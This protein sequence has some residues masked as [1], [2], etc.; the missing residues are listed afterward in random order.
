MRL[1][2][3]QRRG[4][5]SPSAFNTPLEMLGDL[6][7]MAQMLTQINFQYSIGDAARMRTRRRCG[8]RPV[9]SILHWRCIK[10]KA[11]FTKQ[12]GRRPLSILHWRCPCDLLF[13]DITVITT[14]QYSIGDALLPAPKGRVCEHLLSILHWRCEW[15]KKV[16][17]FQ[18]LYAFNTPL[19]MLAQVEVVVFMP[20]RHP[21]NTPLEMQR[22]GSGLPARDAAVAFNTPLEMRQNDSCG[23]R[24]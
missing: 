2:R 4:G 11:G 1:R 5:G 14:F 19:E 16:E 9:L 7:D 15:Q 18:K 8:L 10:K 3:G 13:I 21:F 24:A 17:E 12:G 20:A 23:T 6:R 22:D